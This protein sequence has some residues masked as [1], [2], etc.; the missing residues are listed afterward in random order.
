MYDKIKHP[1]TGKW[2]KSESLQ[3]KQIL[4]KYKKMI[5]HTGGSNQCINFITNNTCSKAVVEG[6]PYLVNKYINYIDKGGIGIICGEKG[7]VRTS[8]NILKIQLTPESEL[9]LK[10]EG[11]GH[12]VITSFIEDAQLHGIV[13]GPGKI[14]E[15]KCE[16]NFKKV[17]TALIKRRI[18]GFDLGTRLNDKKFLGY[19]REANK[20]S[21]GQVPTRETDSEPQGIHPLDLRNEIRN[22]LRTF[23]LRTGYSTPL[24][25]IKPANLMY[26]NFAENTTRNVILADYIIKE[27]Y[28]WTAN[29]SAEVWSYW[30]SQSE[31][32]T[33]LNVNKGRGIL[34]TQ[35]GI[36]GTEEEKHQCRRLQMR[37]TSFKAE[38]DRKKKFI[39][40]AKLTWSPITETDIDIYNTAN[41]YTKLIGSHPLINYCVDNANFY[42]I[43][44]FHIEKSLIDY[45]NS[46]HDIRERHTSK[47]QELTT[48]L[49]ALTPYNRKNLSE[50]P[51]NLLP[52]VEKII[53]MFEMVINDM[54]KKN[55]LLTVKRYLE[56]LNSNVVKDKIFRCISMRLENYKD[57]MIGYDM[58]CEQLKN[59]CICPNTFLTKQVGKILS[60]S[61]LYKQIF[62][63]TSSSI[64]VDSFIQMSKDMNSKSVMDISHSRIYYTEDTLNLKLNVVTKEE[65]DSLKSVRLIRENSIDTKKK[66]SLSSIDEPFSNLTE[67]EKGFVIS[68]LWN[69]EYLFLSSSLT[70][71]K[72]LE[73]LRKRYIKILNS[74]KCSPCDGFI[75][76]E[77]KRCIPTQWSLRRHQHLGCDND[78][79]WTLCK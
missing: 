16:N 35:Y 60:K 22:K 36:L 8:K 59:K 26:G 12:N 69:E 29:D 28:V 33:E 41:V 58:I 38:P 77:C 68:K 75:C 51:V 74:D 76:I 57:L 62:E 54:P 11:D 17:S 71:F 78:F 50:V 66:Y 67:S 42:S 23:L 64:A 45:Y 4:N 6:Q 24:G 18:Y 72:H 1:K 40:V 52:S 31:N 21:P 7:T 15:L 27:P 10:D 3:G 79:Y 53:K 55:I 56:I 61:P 34:Q 63:K 32:P 20:F 48:L 5:N 44:F 14:T 73:M 46:C 25:D 65:Y 9:A 13:V 43:E 30:G 49:R 37:L 39:E 70:S 47:Y 19:A 2:I